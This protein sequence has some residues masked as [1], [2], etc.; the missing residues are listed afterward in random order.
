MVQVAP[1]L[2]R[3]VRDRVGDCGS[4]RLFSILL[5]RQP[6]HGWLKVAPLS[7]RELAFYARRVGEDALQEILDRQGGN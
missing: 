2:A 4:C 7:D 1:E 6:E 3:Q 5:A